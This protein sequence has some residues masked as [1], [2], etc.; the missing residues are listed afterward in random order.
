MRLCR[1]DRRNDTFADTCQNRFL[2]G[3][4][5][6]LLDIGPH[7]NARLGDQ[8]NTVLGHCSYRRSIDDFG[9]DRHLYRFEYIAARQIDRRSHLEIEHNIGFLGRHQRMHHIG[10]VTSGQIVGFELV[11]IEFQTIVEGGTL[12]QRIKINC[13]KLIRTPDTSAEN[14]K[15]TGMK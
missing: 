3:T 7:R 15:P 9:I 2:T 8:L 6:Q 10:H 11:G 12:R 4:A 1:A 13:N 14:H 5:D